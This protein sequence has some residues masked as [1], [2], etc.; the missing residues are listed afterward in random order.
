MKVGTVTLR[1]A[2]AV[3][4]AAGLLLG[5]TGV[6]HA[7]DVLFLHA[8]A[9]DPGL[10][11]F[12][13]AR[14]GGNFVNDWDQS[15]QP[16]ALPSDV[17]TYKAYIIA[18][19]ANLSPAERSTLESCAKPELFLGQGG[20]DYLTDGMPGVT[21]NATSGFGGQSSGPFSTDHRIFNYPNVIPTV[22]GR[23]VIYAGPANGY[24]FDGYLTI[25][26]ATA[27]RYEGLAE[28]DDLLNPPRWTILQA[29]RRYF[30]WAWDNI[31]T[32]ASLTPEGENLFVNLI[33]FLIADDD[34]DSVTNIFDDDDDGDGLTDREELTR[35][36]QMWN[37]DSDGDGV[38]D[39]RDT[40]P[41]LSSD[42][43]ESD[44]EE[45]M[46]TD[47]PYWPWT[48]DIS[49]EKVCW[50]DARTSDHLIEINDLG[51]GGNFT[52]GG[53]VDF[54]RP[55]ISGDMVAWEQWNNA[56]LFWETWVTD[57]FGGSIPAGNSGSASPFPDISGDRIVYN[58]RNAQ[59]AL[60]V[61]WQD[62]TTGIETPIDD[63]T[64]P[65]WYP[66]ID[67]D[68]IIWADF[69]DDPD[70]EVY[71]YHIPTGTVTRITDD[72][73]AG[74]VSY[75]NTLFDI[76]GNRV[77]YDTSKATGE[78]DV[79]VF[80]LQTGV[81]S[82]VSDLVGIDETNP[83]ISGDFVAWVQEDG[84][85]SDVY[86]KNLS[87]GGPPVR[88][89]TD[90]TSGKY[91]LS[92]SGER[93]AWLDGSLEQIFVRTGDIIPDGS[94]NC[95]TVYNPLQE[96]SLDSDGVGDAC[97]NCP[98][99]DNPNQWDFDLDGLGNRCDDCT[100]VDG[101]GY[102]DTGTEIVAYP[103]TGCVSNQVDCDDSLALVNPAATEICNGI[104]DNC[105][106]TVDEPGDIDGDGVNDNLDI[107]PYTHD[108]AQSEDPADTDNI[109]EAC[110]ANFTVNL[111]RAGTGTISGD[112]SYYSPSCPGTGY[113]GAIVQADQTADY[114]F[115][116]N[117]TVS[118]TATATPGYTFTGWTGWCSGLGDCYISSVDPAPYVLTANF[119]IDT[120]SCID[121]DGDGYG[122]PASPSCP[123]GDV[124]DCFD[125]DPLGFPDASIM[126]PGNPETCDGI[127]NNC[128]G[129][130]D[131]TFTDTD[132]DGLGDP[133][134]DDAD[135]DGVLNTD[136][137]CPLVYNVTQSDFDG[138]SIG[139]L[140][141]PD[142]DGDGY[143]ASCEEGD[144]GC[145]A[146]CNDDDPSIYP[147]VGE[148][149][150]FGLAPKPKNPP[151]SDRDGLADTADNCPSVRNEDQADSDGDGIGDACDLCPN[152]PLN[153]ND[154]GDGVCA[155]TG[156]AVPGWLAPKTGENDNCPDDSN[157]DQA[158]LDGDLLGN[159]CDDDADDDGAPKPDDCNDLD[160][161]IK[162]ASYGG[163]ET[164]GNTIDD[165]CDPATSDNAAGDIIFAFTDTNGTPALSYAAWLP[166]DGGTAAVALSITSECR[167]NTS[168]VPITV[169]WVSSAYTGRYTNHGV[170]VDVGGDGFED[171]D[172]T[173]TGMTN[174]DTIAGGG[175]IG[176][177]SHD[178]GGTI[179]F[180]A[181]AEF[182]CDDLATTAH[183]EKT[184]TLPLNSDA[185]ETDTLPDAWE[186][187]YG[188][189]Q[190]GDD[191]EVSPGSPNNWD[192]QTARQEYRGYK[193]GKLEASDS[194]IYQTAAYVPTGV[195]AGAMSFFRSDPTRKTLFI[196]YYG[197]HGTP[198]AQAGTPVI[199]EHYAFA[200][201]HALYEA[202]LEAYAADS[203]LAEAAGEA[204]IKMVR[205]LL[206]TTGLASNGEDGHINKLG[207]R[208]F[209]FDYLGKSGYG[210]LTNFGQATTLYWRSFE[211]YFND[212]PYREET[213]LGEGNFLD[214]LFVVEDANDNGVLDTRGKGED[215]DKSGDLSGDYV[216][217]GSYGEDLTTFDIDSDG[218]F[219][220][221]VAATINGI[222]GGNE[223]S[224]AQIVKHVTIH[225][226]GH[227]L[228]MRHNAIGGCLMF[229][230]STDWRRDHFFSATAKGEMVFPQ[231]PQ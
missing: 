107:C 192:G 22:N 27:L 50:E 163:V 106:G 121:L 179:T 159:V 155:G 123:G 92:I 65:Q 187:N 102:G 172:F 55:R 58:K 185:S 34:A 36:T 117:T 175:T 134:D 116:E 140:C 158:D 189:L 128:D 229:D 103:T 51:F 41:L 37:A 136:D 156:D 222:T 167:T 62:L 109:G 64:D 89:S 38:I 32:E 204:N 81:A 162:P 200:V 93:V 191:N 173:V 105:D 90:A 152:D 149:I 178:Y 48:V 154:Q 224:R 161:G 26:D 142:A 166:T 221:P 76:S 231:I 7:Q 208:D 122:D 210:S 150:E 217:L 199:T 127:D 74:P 133:C 97:D 198:E 25:N 177:T 42:S 83:A 98:T 228:G 86:M 113:G 135:S 31:P 220:L 68:N 223:N 35:G 195:G 67:G 6:T 145:F 174:G 54:E 143:P 77:V 24:P 201:G 118:F 132:G 17:C 205:I 63:T 21:L 18:G 59:G 188:D 225:E 203:S 193:W 23:A 164:P 75:N 216:V 207:A 171:D 4:I 33:D 184:W 186:S 144:T 212:K 82:P 95:P 153:D 3:L 52:F 53:L 213:R 112:F 72:S 211:G 114:V 170:M 87:T 190:D 227:A 30:H 78:L 165:D 111:S 15:E 168:A 79:W 19:D 73:T 84:A 230:A 13:D 214:P 169:N 61:Y 148:C 40:F 182:L 119:I 100:D 139:D 110:E 108:P 125:A 46:L 138:D 49:G 180:T 183:M 124:L 16:S 56:G 115:I 47:D 71:R 141:D 28:L 196:K 176:L 99:V 5:H 206:N 130:S 66:V 45:I 70:A 181:I 146:D 14:F 226:I 69:R 29:N 57:S 129:Y 137:N 8:A 194:T 120:G 96:E 101:D 104:D 126:F 94:D 80:D 39:L 20:R 160:P 215:R 202:G 12:L 11:P 219:E 197:Y 10:K 218:N 147:G 9:P 2:F 43:T 209:S 44:Y 157:S 151:D 85:N 91:Y 131:E 88:I 1:V 60:K